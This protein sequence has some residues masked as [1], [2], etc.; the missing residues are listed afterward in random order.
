VN[1]LRILSALEGSSGVHKIVRSL[2]LIPHARTWN[3][4]LP[5]QFHFRLRV[6]HADELTD[7]CTPQLSTQLSALLVRGSIRLRLLPHLPRRG[8]TGVEALAYSRVAVVSHQSLF[9]TGWICSCEC[10]H[11]VW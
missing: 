5:C 6:P 2:L 3:L 7:V 8:R 9:Y 4:R 1:T 11:G 10:S